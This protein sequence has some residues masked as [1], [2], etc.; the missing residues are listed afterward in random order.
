MDVQ[1]PE[2]RRIGRSLNQVN[3]LRVYWGSASIPGRNIEI[4]KA[5]HDHAVEFEGPGIMAS[6]KIS[7]TF[8]VERSANGEAVRAAVNDC[9]YADVGRLGDTR[10]DI[11][12]RTVTDP[13]AAGSGFIPVPLDAQGNPIFPASGFVFRSR[14]DPIAGRAFVS[15]NHIRSVP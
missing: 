7:F 13:F 14:L 11:V 1:S 3:L 5:R 4:F 9:H 6:S 15:C 2:G 8:A 12:C 10:S